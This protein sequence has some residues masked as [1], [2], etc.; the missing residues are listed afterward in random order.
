M[1]YEPAESSTGLFGGNSNWRG[2]I[3]FP[4]NFLLIES[5][6]KFHHYFGEDFKVQFPSGSGNKKQPVGGSGGDL[7]AAYHESSIAGRGGGRYRAARDVSER[8]ALEGFHSVLRILSRRQRR[9]RRRKS[10][11]RVDGPG[12]EATSNKVV[13]RSGDKHNSLRTCASRSTLIS[14]LR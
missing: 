7:A 10:S 9:G 3:W 1:D 11:D 14:F 8:S 13:S 2:P 6:Q 5:L 12:R 4:V